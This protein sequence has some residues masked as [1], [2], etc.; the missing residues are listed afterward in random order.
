MQIKVISGRDEIPLLLPNEKI[1]HIGFRPSNKDIFGIVEACPKIEA[2]Q[3]PPS[4]FV[5]I[6]KSIQIFLRMQKIQLLEG[7]VGGHRKDLHPYYVVPEYIIE[8][9]KELKEDG[10][11]PDDIVKYVSRLHRMSEPLAAYVVQSVKMSTT[12]R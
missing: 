2:I 10:T 12:P 9:I 3:V 6:S 1:V 7:D 4:Y 5:S 8:K 11:R